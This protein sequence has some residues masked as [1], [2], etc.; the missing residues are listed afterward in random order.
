LLFIAPFL[1]PSGIGAGAGREYRLR[2]YHTH[3]RE[4]LDTVYRHGDAYS[5]E[6]LAELDHFLRDHRTGEVRHFD[7]RVFDL[8]HDLTAAVN[9]SEG[10]K[11]ASPLI[12][13]ALIADHNRKGSVVAPG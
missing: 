10:E 3:T 1:H 2:F 4:R 12:R 7:P 5:P 13:L 11:T 6:A 9:D 8:L